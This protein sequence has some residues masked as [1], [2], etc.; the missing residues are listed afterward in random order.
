MSETTT[1]PATVHGSV[2]TYDVTD[3]DFPGVV[4]G[5]LGADDL[6]TLHRLNRRND[7]THHDQDSD[8]HSIFYREYDSVRGLYDRFLREWILPL[9]GEDLAVQ[10]VPT[11]RVHR[12]GGVA[13]SSFHTDAQYNHQPATMNYWLPLTR[14]FGTNSMWIED[15]AGTDTYSPAVV[16]P[17]EVFRF[18][19][20]NNRHGNYPNETDVSRVSFDFRAMPLRDFVDHGLSTVNANRRMD[21]EG[22][23]R[24][25]F[26]DGTFG[27]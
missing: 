5:I 23:Y 26:A 20:V 17:G 24:R 12:P 6:E 1:S 19:A 25:L 22:Y 18:D 11:F 2:L 7:P 16:S 3:F 21:L 9:Y 4:A 13:V 27:A 8:D 14:A 15:A 10:R